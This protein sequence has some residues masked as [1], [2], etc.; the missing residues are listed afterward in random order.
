MPIF[1]VNRLLP[2]EQEGRRKTFSDQFAL[3]V[4]RKRKKG[5]DGKIGD[6][7]VIIRKVLPQKNEA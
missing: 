3:L 5:K 4:M 7:S 2:I 6:L 1:N